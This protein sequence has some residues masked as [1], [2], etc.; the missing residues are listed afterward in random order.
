M[1]YLTYVTRA[2]A[3][4]AL[5]SFAPAAFS[6]VI[7][8][9]A[10]PQSLNGAWEFGCGGPDPEDDLFTDYNELLVFD[11]DVV[12]AQAL[13]FS[14]TDG[15]CSGGSSLETLVTGTVLSYDFVMTPSWQDSIIPQRLDGAGP[16]SNDPVVTPLAF[17]VPGEPLE[18]AFFY[19]DNTILAL[20]GEACLYRN[21]DSDDPQFYSNFISAEE[22]LCKIDL[23]VNPIPVPASIWLFG[24]AL[25]GF[26]AYSRRR[27]IG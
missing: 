21:G 3:F 27:K 17:A 12:K 9:E 4:L 5:L 13:V 15:S 2:L 11:G 16:L 1:S 18:L 24:T 25:T 19:M 7:N 6:V 14:S 22:P 10:G 8:G 20:T 26:V 23:D